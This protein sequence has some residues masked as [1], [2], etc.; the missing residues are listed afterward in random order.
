MIYTDNISQIVKVYKRFEKNYQT[1]EKYRSENNEK[2][3]SEKITLHGIPN[4][5]PLL[6][7]FETC[8]GF[9]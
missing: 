2:T 1:R 6:S 9:K 5:D 3:E 8:N 7:L 4:R